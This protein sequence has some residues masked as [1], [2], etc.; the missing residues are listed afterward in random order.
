MNKNIFHKTLSVNYNYYILQ[1]LKP[2]IIISM[3]I[4]ASL[5]HKKLARYLAEELNCQYVETYITASDDTET[6]VQILEDMHKCDVV[7]V[8]STFR[9]ANNHLMEL[10]LLVDTV[11]IS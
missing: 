5:S 7:I 9:P 6:R 8:Q 3:K 1:K 10:L 4:L 11:I 2:I